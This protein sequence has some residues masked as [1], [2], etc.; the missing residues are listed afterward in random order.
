MARYINANLIRYKDLPF[1]ANDEV[2]VYVGYSSKSEI[3][4]IPT[5]DVQEVK[6]GYWIDTTAY[7]GEFTCSICKETCVTNKYKYCPHCGAKMSGENTIVTK[8]SIDNIPTADVTEVKHGR[9]ISEL[10]KKSD[11]RGKIQKYYQPHS[12]SCCH[13]PLYGTEKYCS[14]CGAKMDGGSK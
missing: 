6:H 2:G 12:C 4:A 13:T 8:S 5:A 3:D 1:S 14:N 10:V 7:C 9:F 11:W